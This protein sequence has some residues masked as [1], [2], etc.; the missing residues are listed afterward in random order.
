M[1]AET[2][3]IS[4]ELI[5][6][7]SHTHS[8]NTLDKSNRSLLIAT[9]LNVLITAVEI[10]GGIMANSPALLSDAAHNLSDT[11][12]ILLAYIA[13]R[14][15]YRKSNERKTFGY[16]RIEILAAFINALILIGI[17][18]FLVIEAI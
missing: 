11:I 17:S 16:K 15:S 6:P 8:H 13:R 7:M 14:I 5:Q 18:A 10:I 4:K 2:V 3:V 9:L 1:H 12:A